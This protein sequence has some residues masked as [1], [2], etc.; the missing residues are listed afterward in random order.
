MIF[1]R[2]C[3]E[4]GFADKKPFGDLVYFLSR[5]LI[6][7]TDYGFEIIEIET[8][9]K[10]GL[11]RRM[12]SSKKL[13]GDSE[14]YMYPNQVLLFDRANLI[15]LAKE[16]FDKTGRRCTIFKGFDEH[17]TF[18]IDADLSGLLKIYLYDAEPPWP[19]LSEIV[20]S[21]EKTGIF[22]ELEIEFEHIIRDIRDAEASVYPCRAGGFDVTLDE[23]R[24]SGGEKVAGCL[25]ARQFLAECYDGDFE[26]ENICPADRAADEKKSPYVARCCR[27]ERCGLKTEDGITGYVVHWGASPKIIADA[28][29]DLCRIYQEK[30]KV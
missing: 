2:Q 16:S 4:V 22:G 6:K 15:R 9:G 29:F 17:M 1:P 14:T 11:L 28:V 5:Y 21:L 13:A 12:K 10:T 19:N 23:D 24:L 3:K 8:E 18:V 20:K 27:A 25:T 26:I 7:K 30:N